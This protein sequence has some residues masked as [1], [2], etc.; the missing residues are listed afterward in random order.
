VARVFLG[1]VIDN[2]N[3][4]ELLECIKHYK[5]VFLDTY[6][7]NSNSVIIGKEIPTTSYITQIDLNKLTESTLD[8]ILIRINS[9][10]NPK[11]IRFLSDL[12]LIVKE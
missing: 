11:R 2:K 9:K 3:E 6:L 7:V 1:V 8:Y 5:S 12:K 10:W 4:K